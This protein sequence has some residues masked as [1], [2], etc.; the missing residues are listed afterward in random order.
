MTELAIAVIAGAGG[1]IATAIVIYLVHHSA[2][3]AEHEVIKEVRRSSEL[4]ARVSLLDGKLL[5]ATTSAE[6]WKARAQEQEARAND[7]TIDLLDLAAQMPVSGA[8]E[9]V[10][11][12]WNKTGSGR[13]ATSG[14]G[15][16]LV[17][18]EPRAAGSDDLE[19]P[20]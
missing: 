15:P 12:R 3:G 4:A 17:P 16:V 18:A 19:K 11:S 5:A 2:I 6:T 8:R 1:V 20:E 13:P 7:V 14:G 10:L 9:R